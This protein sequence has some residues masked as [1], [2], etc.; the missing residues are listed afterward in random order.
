[1]DDRES[2][3]AP[4]QPVVQ[5][6]YSPVRKLTDAEHEQMLQ[7]K[8]L[9]VEVEIALLDESIEKQRSGKDA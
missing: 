3:T 8:L 2:Q 1:M 9:R 4:V 6:W 7:D 5:S